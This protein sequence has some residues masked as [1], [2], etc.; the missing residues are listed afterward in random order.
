MQPVKTI[1]IEDSRTPI[2][3]RIA[4][5]LGTELLR[6][7]FEV[8]LIKPDGFNSASFHEF[9][10][11]QGGAA[12]VSN[13]SSNA[14]QA[15]RPDSGAFFFESFPGRLIFLH[16]D[17]IL[18]GMG[19]LNGIGK[20]QAWQRVAMRSAHLCIEAD[21]VADLQAVG[22][23]NA[24]LV[25]HASE[26]L[27]AEPSLQ[28]FDF[29][30]SFVGHVVPAG[31]YP[32]SGASPRFQ[33]LIAAALE[34]RRKDLGCAIEPLVKAYAEQALDGLGTADDQAV[35]RVAH[36]QWLRNEIT[37]QTLPFRGWAFEQCGIE[38]LAIFG[39]DPAYLHN[40][41]RNL[42]VE[43]PGVAYHPAVYEPQDV[44]R[45]FNRSR[46]NINISSLQFD[47]AVVNRVHDVFMAGGLCLTYARDGLAQLTAAHAE[48]SFR[49][50]GELRDRA[51]YFTRPAA[52][53]ERAA[54]IRRVQQDI[55]HNAGYPLLTQSIAEALSRL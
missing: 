43:R 21:N 17:A 55:L 11:G 29:E 48:I 3:R 52:A 42:R 54:L 2:Y 40:V 18:G 37:G 28:A 23:E 9:L 6:R 1:Y 20:L 7:G 51:A 19:L 22:I 32:P 12:Y 24:Q 50:L 27:P 16:Q 15:R 26:T 35:L 41:A 14:I 34:A 31:H 44:Q 25:G 10:Q 33:A 45:V 30:A 49:T 13:A 5:S 46:V 38:R 4:Q 39:G 47:H 53:A 8:L 36:A